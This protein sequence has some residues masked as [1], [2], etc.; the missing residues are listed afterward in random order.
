MRRVTLAACALAM[1][2]VATPAL[3]RQTKPSWVAAWGMPTAAWGGADIVARPTFTGQTIRMLVRA[4]FGG[5]KVRIR[6]SNA[7]GTQPVTFANPR[8]AVANDDGALVGSGK[9]LTYRGRSVVT[10]PAGRTALSDPVDLTVKALQRLAISYYSGGA[11]GPATGDTDDALA[12][13]ATAKGDHTRDTD[14]SAFGSPSGGGVFLTGV[15]VFAPNDGL[16]VALGDSITAGAQAGSRGWPY[17]LAERFA[18][19]ADQGGPRLSV[20]NMGVSGN[21]LTRTRM[22]LIPGTPPYQG[23]AGLS[24]LVPDALGRSGFKT[25]LM[26]EGINDIGAD[27]IPANT[28]TAAYA[29]TAR[30][31]HTAGGRFLLSPLTPSGDA[32][33]PTFYGAGYWDPD[34]VRERHDVNDWIRAH[35]GHYS[36]GFDFDHVVADPQ[37]PDHLVAAYNSGDNLHPNLAGQQAMAASIDLA[38]LAPAGRS[39]VNGPR[40]MP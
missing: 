10:I 19:L 8:I 29:E 11:T 37:E 17:W 22:P 15:D 34:G 35:S 5:S 33:G 2:L 30:R 31:V 18:A 7:D 9:P 32:Y 6:L 4:S 1:L 13:Y 12:T 16:V 28:L 23:A 27:S 20:I 3:A 14:A 36:T 24:R 25:L 26:M 39:A 38:P 21:D 40:G